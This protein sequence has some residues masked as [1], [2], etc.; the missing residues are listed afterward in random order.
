MAL[1]LQHAQIVI[2]YAVP[3]TTS[4]TYWHWTNDRNFFDLLTGER[5]MGT[6]TQFLAHYMQGGMGQNRQGGPGIYVCTNQ[7]DSASYGN[8]LVQ[9]DV[10]SGVRLLDLGN[11]SLPPG[12]RNQGFTYQDVLTSTDLPLLVKYR[13]TFIAVKT[14]KGVG[15]NPG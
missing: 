13:T 6:R 3:L 7:V 9:V 15:Y 8:L 5:Y 2:N 4:Q 12:L 10:A 14:H 1:S 11:G